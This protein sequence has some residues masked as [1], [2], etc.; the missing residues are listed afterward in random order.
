MLG[1]RLLTAAIGIPILVAAIWFGQGAFT[2]LVTV[3][4][5]GLVLEFSGMAGAA[6][7]RPLTPLLLFFATPLA[8]ILVFRDI[9]TAALWTILFIGSLMIAKVFYHETVTISRLGATVLGFFYVG[10]LPA[11]LAL[12]YHQGSGP[13][14][15]L[16]LFVSIWVA[17]SSAYFIG[18]LFGRTPLSPSLSPNKTLEG[19]L[20]SIIVTALALKYLWVFGELSAGERMMFG[21]GMASMAILGD[22][23]ESSLKREAGLKDSGFILPGHGGLLDRVDS[24]LAA[25]PL[26]YFLLA[27]WS[28]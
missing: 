22:L 26:A 20:G 28:N 23:F 12:S 3:V 9:S 6:G 10:I 1:K 4:V 17:D 19:A 11:V 24:L 7:A 15:I 13:Y 2:A 8:A 16:M 18:R 27:V 21:V 25:A 5:V 14:S